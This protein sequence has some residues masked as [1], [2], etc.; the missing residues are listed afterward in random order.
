MDHVKPLR[1]SLI[2]TPAV[3]LLRTRASYD[4]L[5]A[6][7]GSLYVWSKASYIVGTMP[8]RLPARIASARASYRS[9]N[10]SAMG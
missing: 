8:A 1:C 5:R 6:A 2:P 9:R 4:F 10:G 3:N 7:S